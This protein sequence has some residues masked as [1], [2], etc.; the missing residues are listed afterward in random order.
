M[1]KSIALILA[2][3]ETKCKQAGAWYDGITHWLGFSKEGYYR[4]GHAAIALVDGRNGIVKYFDFGRYHAPHGH[5]RVRDEETDWELAV[6]TVV[7]WENGI[8]LNL[9]ELV[10]ELQANKA[11]H[12]DGKMEVGILPI[13]FEK[14]FAKALVMQSE[15]FWVYGPFVKKGTNCSR[16]V[17]SVAVAGSKKPFRSVKMNLP[18]MLSPTPMWNVVSG[19][20]INNYL[21]KQNSKRTQ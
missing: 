12:G 16:F 10:D 18:W 4:V 19:Y 11:C 2:W 5:G 3:P 6:N 20:S 7:Q 21:S 15:E 13:D 8:P 9:N 14:S 1:E 17:R